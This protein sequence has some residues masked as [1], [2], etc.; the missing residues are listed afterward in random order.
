MD[1]ST[2]PRR[3]SREAHEAWLRDHILPVLGGPEVVRRHRGRHPSV[4][5]SLV[6]AGKGR[7]TVALHPVLHRMFV[8]TVDEDP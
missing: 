2:H 6:T 5:G 4:R 1:R 8:V 7:R 3:K